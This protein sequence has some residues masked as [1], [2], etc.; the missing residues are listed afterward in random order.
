MTKE[1][2]KQIKI[3]TLEE[4]IV[5]VTNT[6]AVM[7]VASGMFN[8]EAKS[9]SEPYIAGA[10]SVVSAIEELKKKVEKDE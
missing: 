7:E 1:E 8:D 10:K 5:L 9:I 3:E 2:V 4:I 6:V